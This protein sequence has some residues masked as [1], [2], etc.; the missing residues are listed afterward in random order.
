MIDCYPDNFNHSQQITHSEKMLIIATRWNGIGNCIVA[1]L[2]PIS[3]PEPTCLLVSTK[4]RSL[5][6]D[7]KAR[8]LWERDWFAAVWYRRATS[9]E[10]TVRKLLFSVVKRTFLFDMYFN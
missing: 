6:A 8:G 9:L 2:P 4:T 5:G 10:L 7:Q 3:F 1:S